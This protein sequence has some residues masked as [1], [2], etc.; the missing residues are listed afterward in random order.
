MENNEKI[1]INWYPNSL[2]EARLGAISGT[3]LGS[4]DC[5]LNIPTDNNCSQRY[6]Q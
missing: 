6:D 3:V 1:A 5:N 4:P 2:V